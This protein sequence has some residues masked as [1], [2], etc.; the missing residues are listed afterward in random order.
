MRTEPVVVLSAAAGYGKSIFAAQMCQSDSRACAWCSMLESDNDPLALINHI[1]GALGEIRAVPDWYL[2]ACRHPS[3]RGE[4]GLLPGLVDLMVDCA[5]FMLVLDDLHLVTS[6]RSEALLRDVVRALPA[7]CRLTI[8][9]R[10]DPE[11]GLARLRVAQQVAEVRAPALA[12]DRDE[13]SLFLDAAG[14][15]HDSAAVAELERITE[16]WPAGVALTTLSLDTPALAADT[17]REFSGSGHDVAEFLF[18][19]VLARQEPSIRTFLIETSVVQRMSS[20][21]CDFMLERSGSGD[22]LRQLERT[23]LF[24]VALDEQHEWFRYHHLFR[25]MLRIELDR[26]EPDRARALLRRAGVWHER[27]GASEEAFEYARVAGDFRLAGRVAL[28][29][30]EE[31]VHFGRLESLRLWLMKCRDDQIES[32]TAL[33]IGAGWV[34]AQL[35]DGERAERYLAAAERGDDLDEPSPDGATSLR[36]QMVNLRSVI[37]TRGVAQ[38][39]EDGRY[40]YASESARGGRDGCWEHAARSG[41]PM[42]CWGSL[43]RRL[44]SSKRPWCSRRNATS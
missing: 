5:P 24:I 42:S 38:M 19:E 4:A 37:G 26:T 28:R 17:V 32:D 10:A 15:A 29:H 35:G 43:T 16:G 11:I 25:D 31:Y 40:V 18:E 14:V 27:D 36:S 20:R 41:S 34:F 9:T 2:E 1:V 23:N 3:T 22:I 30:W 44:R 8:G 12:L 33:S 13:I 6:A 21:L 39:L 7:G